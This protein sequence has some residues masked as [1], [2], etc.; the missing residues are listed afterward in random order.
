M[1]ST[2]RG[3]SHEKG[4]LPR[5]INDLCGEVV[6]LLQTG[7][8]RHRAAIARLQDLH[9]EAEPYDLP[10][11]VTGTPEVWL[12]SG[13]KPQPNEKTTDAP[14]RTEILLHITVH[15]TPVMSPAERIIRHQSKQEKVTVHP[16]VAGFYLPHETANVLVEA[17]HW[18]DIGGYWELAE[19]HAR[20]LAEALETHP[21]KVDPHK[22]FPLM[23][24][25]AARLQKVSP[26]LA[27]RI[28]DAMTSV[29]ARDE[30]TLKIEREGVESGRIKPKAELYPH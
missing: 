28:R 29:V 21:L 16:T 13:P 26:D 18:A 19:A 23:S 30:K 20:A 17:M 24:K 1:T 10:I 2:E 9:R 7:D 14:P 8:A 6:E 25:Y 4:R 3:S 11:K 27:K 12:H 15:F 5:S 22:K